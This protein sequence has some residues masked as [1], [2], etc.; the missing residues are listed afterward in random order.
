ML[1]MTSKILKAN[2]MPKKMSKKLWMKRRALKKL[3]ALLKRNL[4]KPRARS[5]NQKLRKSSNQLK[6]D[7][8]MLDQLLVKYKVK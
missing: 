6:R 4:C 5:K 2:I 7:L 3:L 1:R 8:K